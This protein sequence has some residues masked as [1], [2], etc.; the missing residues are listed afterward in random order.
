MPM[1]LLIFGKLADNT[2]PK[3]MIIFLRLA[4][5]DPLGK[6]K[7]FPTFILLSKS[8]ISQCG[9]IPLLL[10]TNLEAVLSIPSTAR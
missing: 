1:A 2:L 9:N 3:V 10:V 4:R 5:C 8:I 7:I 6:I